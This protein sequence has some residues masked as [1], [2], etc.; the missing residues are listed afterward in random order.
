MEPGTL[1]VIADLDFRVGQLAQLLDS[2]Y[3]GGTHVGGGD[4]AQFA[5]VLGE[6]P[7]LVHE[8]AQAAPLDEGHQ[9]VD[10]VGRHDFLF[11]LGVHLRFVDGT[12]KQRTLCQRH[13]RS[14]NV[15]GRSSGG[16][17]RVIFPQKRKKLLCPLVNAQR[18]KVSFFGG[19]L[20]GAYD[21]VCQLDLCF[22]PAAIVLYV[23]QTLLHHLGQVLRQYLG[24]LCR[25]DGRSG[26]A[27]FRDLCK[28]AV[29][30]V[31]DDLFVQSG[32]EH[33]D[34]SL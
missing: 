34:T 7:Q 31:V 30:R 3:I 15:L 5:A 20:D 21:L 16:K 17:A 32:V 24:C 1:S 26:L 6:L 10:A 2:L 14:L 22:D 19:R 13:F 33:D 23:I 29:Q 18:G 9:H 28:L 8:K 25:V 11:Q 27:G 12:G 4:D